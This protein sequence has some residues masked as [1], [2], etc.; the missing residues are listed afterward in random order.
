MFPTPTTTWLSISASLIAAVRAARR[1][2]KVVGVERRV[3]RLGAEARAAADGRCAGAGNP[4]HRAE[5]ARIVVAQQR[6]R[7][8]ARCRRGRARRRGGRL[9]VERAGCRSCRDARAACPSPMRNSKYLLRRSTRVDRRPADLLRQVGGNRPA[10]APVVHVESRDAAADDV[11]RDAAP[12]GFDFGQFRHGVGRNGAFVALPGDSLTST[13]RRHW[14]A[15][16]PCP[17]RA[18]E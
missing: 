3:E 7:R 15:A 11:R 16:Q 6:R 12:R 4:E 10:Q 8:R 9:A 1:L 13:T 14:R 18:C 5:A 2:P 17:A